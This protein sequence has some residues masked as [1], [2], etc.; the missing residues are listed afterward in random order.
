MED[1]AVKREI[2]D[3]DTQARIKRESADDDASHGTQKKRKREVVVLDDSA[4][5]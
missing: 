5:W 2:G 1:S 3:G 4:S